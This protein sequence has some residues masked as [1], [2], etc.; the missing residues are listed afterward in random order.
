MG[1]CLY[2]MT[3]HLIVGATGKTGRRV[4]DR[5]TQRNAAVYTLSR[6]EFDWANPLTWSSAEVG[7]D[8]AYL[9]YAPD[10]SFPGAPE[11]VA[12]VADR[13]F[14]AGTRNVVLMSGRG[15]PEAQR[16]EGLLADLAFTHDATWS[17]VRS[18]FLMQNFDEGFLAE[19]IALGE[20]QFPADLVREPFVDAEDVADVAAALMLGDVPGNRA[21]ELTGPELLTF[22]EATAHISEATGRPIAYLPI[23]DDEFV[24]G[25]LD[26]GLPA[27]FA[28]GLGELVALELDGRNESLTDGVRLALGRTPRDF[29]GYALAAARSNAWSHALT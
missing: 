11:A 7:A 8:N 21:V 24:A 1:G 20:F 18:A 10:I 26:A 14:A 22:A 23:T 2:L 25:M 6:P 13:M 29:A 16:A 19:S 4:L 5:L 17:A 12:E 28:Q 3:T 9:T 15:A 27:E